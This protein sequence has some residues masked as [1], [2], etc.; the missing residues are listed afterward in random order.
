MVE[1]RVGARDETVTHE[2]WELRVRQGR[3]PAE[4]LVRIQALTGNRFVEAAELAS[5][6]A[7]RDE[8]E[9]ERR[10]ARAVPPLVTALLVGFQIRLWTWAHVA[11]VRSFLLESL[12]N[13][14]PSVFERG[15][16]WRLLT[17]GVLQIELLHAFMNLLWSFFLGWILESTLG[18]VQLLVVFTSSVLVGSLFSA[19]ASPW[20]PSLG[21]SGGVFGL[22]GAVVTF[23]IV[24]TELVGSRLGAAAG[25]FMLPYLLLTFWSGLSS[26]GVDN[27]CHLGGMLTGLALGL[28]LDPPH[29]ERRPRWNVGVWAVLAVVLVGVVSTLGLAG[30]RVLPLW[31]SA[32]AQ[33]E[34]RRRKDG[35]PPP[36][37]PEWRSLAF[38]V[39]GGWL[40]QRDATG[41]QAFGSPVGEHVFGVRA[42][43]HDRPQDAESVLE[44]LRVQVLADWPGARFHAPVPTVLA[45]REGLL[46]LGVTGGEAPRV[47]EYAVA[48]RGVWTLTAVWEVEDPFAA[49]LSPLR[50]R[51]LASVVWDEPEELHTARAADAARSTRDT[52]RTL[53]SALAAVGEREE[54]ERLHAELLARPD[55]DTWRATL[56]DLL[57][58]GASAEEVR[59]LVARMLA[60]DPDRKV[61]VAA[62]D[63]LDAAGDPALAR[64]LLLVAWERT[65]GDRA[66]KRARRSR[67]LTTA[68]LPDGR[69]WDRAWDATG[70]PRPSAEQD[71]RAAWALDLPTATAAAAAWERER[72][73]VTQRMVE[74]LAASDPSVLR[75]LAVLAQGDDTATGQDLQVVVDEALSLEAPSWLPPEL[76]AALAAHADFVRSLRPPDPPPTP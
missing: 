72:A 14:S 50:D 38:S 58:L 67:G 21:S 6:R 5:W 55:D 26:E 28:V 44:A 66:L 11:P 68:L 53:A 35:T 70:A 1:L 48:V 33:A 18:R 46:L 4:A 61:L 30:P 73:A 19:F 62:A 39:P 54:V 31:D 24:R 75:D 56:S 20:V 59:T 36:P 3:V 57:V 76:S 17:M 29:G 41:R 63:A 49:R 37:P 23:G 9:Q 22:V 51:L 10:T 8:A 42:E 69:P 47:L 13:Y 12:M 71:A 45:G 65:P 40:A 64:G 27:W 43:P 7:L 2:E 52:R 16:L 25:V 15:E 74:R 32:A 60:A 34:V